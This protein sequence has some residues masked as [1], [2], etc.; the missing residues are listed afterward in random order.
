MNFSENLRSLRKKNGVLQKDV[1]KVLGIS[2]HGYQN[3]EY[4]I[5]E[6]TMSIMV[7]LADFYNISLDELVGR[8]WP[9][10]A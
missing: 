2:V 9:G 5:N 7:K 10:K 8:E 3:Y 6:P 1:A 4:G